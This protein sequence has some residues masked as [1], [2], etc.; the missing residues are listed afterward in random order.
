MFEFK[1]ENAE[2]EDGGGWLAF[3]RSV[4]ERMSLCEIVGIRGDAVGDKGR[5]KGRR[6]ESLIQDRSRCT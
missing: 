5:G 6:N 1:I 2:L 4:L 3:V